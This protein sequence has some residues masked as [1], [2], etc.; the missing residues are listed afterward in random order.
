MKEIYSR[1]RLVDP[2]LC[3]A[4]GLQ[5]VEIAAG[6]FAPFIATVK[7]LMMRR[8]SARCNLRSFRGNFVPAIFGSPWLAPR[9]RAALSIQGLV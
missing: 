5:R 2:R 7:R 4:G 6:S 3:L 8:S 1:P 9:M